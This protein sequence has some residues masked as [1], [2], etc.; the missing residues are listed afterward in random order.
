VSGLPTAT[1]S[2][3]SVFVIDRSACAVTVVDADALL[4]PG[5]GSV[6]PLVTLAVL[7]NVP[8]VVGVTT[9]V[10]VALAP[11]PRTPMEQITVLV[12][13]QL[14]WLGVADTYVTPAG[15]GSLTLTP[16]ALFGPKLVTVIVYVRF[17]PTNTGSGESV[18][19]SDRSAD[20]P[21]T[22]VVVVALLLPDT[23]S[24]TLLVTLAVLLNVPPAVGVTTIVTVALAAL[25]RVPRLHVTVAV[26][27]QLPCDGVVDTQVT[28][29]G[30]VSVTETPVAELGP[31]FVTVIVYVRFCPTRIGSGESV[32]VTERFAEGFTVVVVVQLLFPVFGSVTP[33]VTLAVL[34]S[35]PTAAAD[36]V[37]TMVTVALAALANVP[38]AHVMVVVPLQLPCVDVADTNV[39]FAGNVSVTVTPVAELGP[40]FV[41]RMLYVSG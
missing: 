32:L 21:L 26:P 23:G 31:L 13:L 36:G 10:T 39:T 6:T 4:L 27:L 33:L 29:P 5:T 40:P 18:L 34:L 8:P 14:P 17:W 24:A 12:P 41:T 3:A 38:I 35:V 16:V 19:L 37:T 1:G 30:S 7:F 2:G 22:V 25:A 28:P 9:M 15:N 11:F 20:K